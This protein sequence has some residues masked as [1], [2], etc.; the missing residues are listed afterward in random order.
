M[1]I[2][3][4]N[5]NLEESVSKNI[6]NNQKD[7]LETTLGKNINTALDIGLKLVL[8]DSIE[9][10]IIDVKNKLLKNGIKDGVKEVVN[11]LVENLKKI[12][13]IITGNFKDVSQVKEC[14]EKDGTIDKISDILKDAINIS[15]DKKIIDKKTGKK[16]KDGEKTILDTISENLEKE[17]EREIKIQNNIEK[18]IEKWKKY[19]EEENF[20]KMEGIMKKIN[21]EKS[22]IFK[23]E[24]L[25]KEIEKIQNIHELIKNKNGTFDLSEL[26]KKIIE[27]IN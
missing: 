22:K 13:G 23:M 14:V 1:E 27:K 10:D 6:K 2:E 19:Y 24:K 16:I 8:P 25:E 7:F 20:N 9:K 5:N 3:I 17:F 18:N 11:S 21:N 26:D 12:K 15:V 4:E